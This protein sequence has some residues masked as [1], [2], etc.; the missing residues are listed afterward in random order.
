MPDPEPPAEESGAASLHVQV[1]ELSGMVMKLDDE[2]GETPAA[3]I[4]SGGMPGMTWRNVTSVNYKTAI[5]CCTWAGRNR[6]A[7][8]TMVSEMH[9]ANVVQRI[10]NII[11]VLRRS[12]EPDPRLSNL[13]RPL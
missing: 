13:L 6:N 5:Q 1:F 4:A 11:L 8:D 9:F 2:D 7:H 3:L 12:A 10:G